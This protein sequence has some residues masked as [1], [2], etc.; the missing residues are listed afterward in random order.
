MSLQTSQGPMAD[1][2]KNLTFALDH[3]FKMPLGLRI[4]VELSGVTVA[5]TWTQ[6]V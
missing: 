5:H 3:I 1:N 2:L 6:T 4:I